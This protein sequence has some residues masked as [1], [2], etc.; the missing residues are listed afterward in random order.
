MVAGQMRSLKPSSRAVL[1][2]SRCQ[3]SVLKIERVLSQL[4]T[5]VRFRMQTQSWTCS[6][7]SG[8]AQHECHVLYS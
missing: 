5:H 1:L 8:H 2:A 4:T 6:H 7:I 3:T